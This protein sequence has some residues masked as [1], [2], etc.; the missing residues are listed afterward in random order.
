M[1]NNNNPKPIQYLFT[2]I[3]ADGL[4]A[5][6]NQILEIALT[7]TDNKLNQIGKSFQS[8]I[9]P[10]YLEVVVHDMLPVVREMHTK[11]GLIAELR[12][13]DDPDALLRTKA[14]Q[15]RVYNVE[16]NILSW[17][18]ELWPE[19]SPSAEI[20]MAGHSINSLDFPFIRTW[21]PEL[22][23]NLSHRTLDIS[24]YVRFITDCCEIPNDQIPFGLKVAGHRAMDDCLMALNEAKK[25]REWNI[26]AC[27][28]M[29]TFNLDRFV[30]I[31]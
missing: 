22:A 2:D 11:N 18:N 19:D 17:L 23:E 15:F 13:L 12:Q 29:R 4:N 9:C 16:R 21:M 28:M 31:D 27:G 6:K 20:R 10:D 14:N 26:T 25:L 30:R 7:L 1:T 8:L 3:E 5:K 24:S